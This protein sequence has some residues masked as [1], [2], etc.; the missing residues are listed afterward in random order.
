M[1]IR[2]TYFFC[3]EK[4]F[5][6]NV[7]SYIWEYTVDRRQHWTSREDVSGE[8]AKI[9][10]VSVCKRCEQNIKDSEIDLTSVLWIFIF[11]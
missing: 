4:V 8:I 1:N 7:L 10:I 9:S 6:E 5:G 3:K 11:R 2:Q